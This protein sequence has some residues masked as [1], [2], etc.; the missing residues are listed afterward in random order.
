M[1]HCLQT[2]LDL[3]RPNVSARVHARQCR[4]KTQHDR[5][6]R[7]RSVAVDDSV[8]VCNFA[9]GQKWLAGTVVTVSG[10]S[11]T[12]ELA[13]GRTVRPH[14]D[15]IRPCTVPHPTSM[16]TDDEL[17][18]VDQLAVKQRI[19]SQLNHLV[20]KGSEN[21]GGLLEFADRLTVLDIDLIGSSFILGGRKY[22]N[23]RT[24]VILEV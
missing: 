20:L 1:G 18:D 15:H 24:V 10:Q 23:H 12:V 14:L 17:L 19:S 16:G 11:V 7:Q 5:H 13:D 21:R 3:M 22:S 8:F 9:T 2:H 4:Q 6:S